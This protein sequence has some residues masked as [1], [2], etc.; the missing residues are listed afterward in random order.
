MQSDGQRPGRGD[1]KQTGCRGVETKSSLL[2][3]KVPCLPR[4]IQIVFQV[5]MTEQKLDAA[6]MMEKKGG[7]QKRFVLC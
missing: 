2:R 5:E 6:F 4:K 7:E 3:Q 1:E